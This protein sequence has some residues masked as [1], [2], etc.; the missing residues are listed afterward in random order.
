MATV[1]K[2]GR[3]FVVPVCYTY[4]GKNLYSPIDKK[5]KQTPAR[6]LKRI[7]NIRDNPYIS[8]VI[9]D[10]YEE[11]IKLCYVIVHG[12]AELLESG[13]DYQMSLRLLCEKYPQYVEMNLPKLNLPV[14]KVVPDRI[15]SWGKI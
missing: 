15:L 2:L 11:W 14:I 13:E 4:D 9:D 10:Y 5:P 1:D 12:R 3:P 6:E 8:I 7:R